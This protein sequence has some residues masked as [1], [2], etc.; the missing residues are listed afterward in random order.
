MIAG[1]FSGF[2]IFF[3]FNIILHCLILSVFVLDFVCCLDFFFSI[4]V[5]EPLVLSVFGKLLSVFEK[6]IGPLRIFWVSHPYFVFLALVVNHFLFWQYI[7]LVSS[8]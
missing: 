6:F 8:L 4:Q 5:P 3:Q 2:S 1:L 7:Y